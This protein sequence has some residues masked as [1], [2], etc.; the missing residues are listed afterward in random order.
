MSQIKGAS[1]SHGAISRYVDCQRLYKHLANKRNERLIMYILKISFLGTFKCICFVSFWMKRQRLFSFLKFSIL[2]EK[3]PNKRRKKKSF[4]LFLAIWQLKT[5]LYARVSRSLFLMTSH[6]P[7]APKRHKEAGRASH[8]TPRA[9]TVGL[10]K[11]EA[12]RGHGHLTL[13]ENITEN[14]SRQHIW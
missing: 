14:P 4:L 13:T 11:R 3:D 7:G 1:V 12:P 9:D 8:R 6:Q 2:D 10:R 5:T